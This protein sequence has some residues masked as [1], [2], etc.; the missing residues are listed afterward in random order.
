M[1]PLGEFR[2]MYKLNKIYE[3]QAFGFASHEVPAALFIRQASELLSI[4]IMREKW[5]ADRRDG[6]ILKRNE[7]EYDSWGMGEHGGDE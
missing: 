1:Y 5:I 2:S 6:K 7:E 4:C 3:K